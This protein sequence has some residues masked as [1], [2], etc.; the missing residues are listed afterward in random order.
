MGLSPRSEFTPPFPGFRVSASLPS[1]IKP[2]STSGSDNHLKR[3]SRKS[4]KTLNN[5]ALDQTSSVFSPRERLP[6]AVKHQHWAFPRSLNNHFLPYKINESTTP[7]AF[8]SAYQECKEEGKPGGT[9]IEQE[10][11]SSI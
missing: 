10:A 5:F 11:N 4:N 1:V 3:L 8:T 6:P 9:D 2:I 7:L